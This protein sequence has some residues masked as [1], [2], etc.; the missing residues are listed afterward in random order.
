ML[1]SRVGCF[2]MFVLMGVRCCS[3]LLRM[4]LLLAFGR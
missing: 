4:L 2:L 1:E 3:M